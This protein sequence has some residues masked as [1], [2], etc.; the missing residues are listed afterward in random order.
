VSDHAGETFGI[1]APVRLTGK[2]MVNDSLCS[3]F[4]VEKIEAQ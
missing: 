4:A 3:M 2:L 1:G